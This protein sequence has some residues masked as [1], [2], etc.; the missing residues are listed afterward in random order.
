MPEEINRV[1]TDHAASLLFA[2]TQ[3]ALCNLQRE[4]ISEERIRL[5]GDVMYDAARQ[6]GAQARLR[7]RILEQLDLPSGGYLLATIHRAESV[8]DPVRRRAIFEGLSRVAEALPVVVPVHPRTRGHLDR[9]PLPFGGDLRLINPVSYLDML[10]LEQEACLIATDSGG[11]QKEA[12]F[13]RVPCVTLR[14]ETE[15][16]ELVE[17][18]WNRLVPPACADAVVEGIR[19]SLG[20]RGEEVEPYGDGH[21]GRRIAELLCRG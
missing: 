20:S 3:A 10:R 19:D 6:F 2:P 12:Y 21:A 1:L 9:E 15:W 16:V 7:S 18:G 8:D 5:V 4:G 14:D 17:A 11:V 13:H